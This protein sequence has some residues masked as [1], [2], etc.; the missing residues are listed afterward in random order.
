MLG[1]KDK[2]RFYFWKMLLTCTFKYPK[3]ISKALTQAIYFAHFEQIFV[4]EFAEE[5][6]SE[7]DLLPIT[8]GVLN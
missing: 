3:S 1:I 7:R 2:N 6:V 5:E 4:N 8:S